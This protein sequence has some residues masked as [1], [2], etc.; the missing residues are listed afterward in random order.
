MIQVGDLVELFRN[1]ST[2]PYE[3]V[4]IDQES[5]MFGKTEGILITERGTGHY[6]W[7]KREELKLIQYKGDRYE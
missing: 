2:T 3:V 1:S 4:T 7:V 6:R 5:V